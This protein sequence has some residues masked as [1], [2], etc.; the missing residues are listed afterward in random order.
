[1][2]RFGKQNWE[3]MFGHWV[4]QPGFYIPKF[5]KNGSLPSKTVSLNMAFGAFHV[6]APTILPA[7]FSNSCQALL[8]PSPRSIHFPKTFRRLM[9]TYLYFYP[10]PPP[11]TCFLILASWWKANMQYLTEFPMPELSGFKAEDMSHSSLYLLVLSRDRYHISVFWYH[12]FLKQNHSTWSDNMN[13]V[14]WR[15]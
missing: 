13:T 5:Y 7:S 12:I 9:E 1:M 15:R 6:L 11:Q 10:N 2:T 3:F 14:R 8:F 4:F